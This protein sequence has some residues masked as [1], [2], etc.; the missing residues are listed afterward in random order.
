[1]PDI[2]LLVPIT[3]ELDITLDELLDGKEIIEVANYTIKNKNKKI[4]ILEIIVLVILLFI[5]FMMG[6]KIYI[7]NIYKNIEYD[8]DKI[9]CSINN[10]EVNITFL[11]YSSFVYTSNKIVDDKNEYI[12]VNGSYNYDGLKS[13]SEKYINQ[14]IYNEKVNNN[15]NVYVYYTKYNNVFNNNIDNNIKNSILICKNK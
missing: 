4:F 14:N 2:S 8:K 6:R 11:N 15:K 9:S 12:F 1:M 13:Y 5:L 10:N 7:D 3:K